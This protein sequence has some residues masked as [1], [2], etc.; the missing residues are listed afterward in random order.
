M[1]ICLVRINKKNRLQIQY[2][3]ANRPLVVVKEGN[4]EEYK[5]DKQPI[6]YYEH[7]QP[8]SAQEI[9]LT[10]DACLYLFSDGYADQF[11]GEKNKKLG[12]KK[13]K[14]MLV[15]ISGKDIKEQEEFLKNYFEKWKTSYPQ[16]DDVTVI[17][18]K[19]L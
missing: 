1:D 15:E 8:F 5:P 4:L 17:G 6:G 2:S 10:K 3:G 9:E 11:G 14:E 13:W 12:T 18:I 16:T 7:A 19:I